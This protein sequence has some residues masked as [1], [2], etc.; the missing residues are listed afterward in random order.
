MNTTAWWGVPSPPTPSLHSRKRH[1]SPFPRLQRP[2][3]GTTVPMTRRYRPTR[4]FPQ[5]FN[6]RHSRGDVTQ[7]C[8]NMYIYHKNIVQKTHAVLLYITFHHP[9]ACG[10]CPEES[11]PSCRFVS[12]RFDSRSDLVSTFRFNSS[13]TIPLLFDPI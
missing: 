7:P 1:A 2:A 11:R 4:G 12:F 8:A 3:V 10:A 6:L 13:R 9:G 5:A